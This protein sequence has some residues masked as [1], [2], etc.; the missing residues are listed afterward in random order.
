MTGMQRLRKFSR[1]AWRHGGMD[2]YT[3]TGAG[4]SGMPYRLFAKGEIA[5]LTLRRKP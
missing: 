1:G 5:L 4:V 3:S 2:G